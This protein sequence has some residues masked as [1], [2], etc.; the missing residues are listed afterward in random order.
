[1]FLT[2]EEWEAVKVED[3]PD[4]LASL[5]LDRGERESLALALAMSAHLLIDEERGR[6]E[7]RRYNVSVRGTLGVLIEAYQRDF[8]TSDQLRFYFS[9]IEE[10]TDIWISPSLC[11]RLLEET[12]NPKN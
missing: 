2:Q 5:H 12:L 7:A 6:E 8:I 9:Q 11:R 3:M 10:R 1:M 4:E